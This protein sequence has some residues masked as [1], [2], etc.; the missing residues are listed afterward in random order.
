MMSYEAGIQLKFATDLPK[1]IGKV[2]SNYAI[3]AGNYFVCVHS[4]EEDQASDWVQITI[5][6]MSNTFRILGFGACFASFLSITEV[7]W[8]HI[9]MIGKFT[10]VIPLPRT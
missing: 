2:I 1:V 9:V 8:N 3:P 6:H 7:I 4:T 10:K 5:N